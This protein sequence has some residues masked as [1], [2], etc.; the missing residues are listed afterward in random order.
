MDK[1]NHKKIISF[2]TVAVAI[3]IALV[4]LLPRLITSPSMPT[5]SPAVRQVNV[6]DTFPE[7][8]TVIPVASSSPAA[9]SSVKGE[10]TVK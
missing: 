10:R 8:K 5:G 4:L 7:N 1:T 3:P 9:T 6:Q 2:A